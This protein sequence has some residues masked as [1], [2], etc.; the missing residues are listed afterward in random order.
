MAVRA[1]AV[2]LLLAAVA[3]AQSPALTTVQDTLFGATGTVTITAAQTFTTAD[4]Y[5][6][7]KG[8]Q[9]VATLGTGGALSVALPPNVGSTPSGTY[10]LAYYQ[11][12][13]G[14]PFTETWVVPSTPTTVDLA[15]V[16]TLLPPT[17]S[18]MFAF[19]QINAPP[20]CGNGQIPQYVAPGWDCVNSSGTGT[21]TSVGLA[22]PSWLAVAGSPVTTTGTLTLAAATGQTTHEVLGTGTGGSVALEALALADLPGSGAATLNTTSPLTGGGSL[23]LGGSLTLACASCLTAIPAPTATTLGGVESY[24]A[25]AHEWFDA[26]STGGVFSAS[27]PTFADLSGAAA[28]G[29]IPNPA[30]DVTGTYAATTVTGLHFG[31]NGYA[32][33]TAALTSGNCLGY[34][35]SNILGVSCGSGM[36][37]PMTAVGDMILGGTGG[38]PTRL[39]IGTSGQCL[40]SN[41][42]TASW[43][44]CSAGS[45]VT[46]ETNSANNS[47][48]TVLN[49]LN[50][51]AF[52]GLTETFTNTSGGDVQAGFSGTLGVGGGGTGLTSITAGD[53]IAGNGTGTPNLVATG[54]QGQVLE[55]NGPGA[56]PSYQDPIISGAYTNLLD[57]AAATATVTGTYTRVWDFSGYATLYVTY[58]GITGSPA[59]C[60]IQ[61]KAGDS[62][63]NVINDGSAI[64]TAPANGTTTANITPGVNTAAGIE[65][66]YAC[67]TYPTAGTVSVDYVP[68]ATVSVPNTVATSASQSGTWTVAQSGTWAQNLTELAGTALGAPAAWGTAPSGDVLGVNANVLALPPLPAG[69]NA[70]GS[71][72]ISNFPATQPVSGTVTA[73]AGTGFRIPATASAA[74][75]DSASGLTQVIAAVTGKA[76][77]VAGYTVVANA[78]VTVQWEYGTGTACA[79]GT[80]ALTGPMSFAA[81]GGAA[82]RQTLFVPSGDALCL[83]LGAAVQ[84]GG[85]VSYAQQ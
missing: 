33:G 40:T 54:T 44:A 61:L 23:A 16:R 52:N 4:G 47:S 41:G 73:D 35:G 9:V 46:L 32:L 11:V 84:V 45:G 3:W 20:G 75:N 13:P 43:G 50:S 31:S 8:Y 83:N 58:A 25:P 77:Y 79:T 18:M 68:Q 5:V 30:G 80:T 81:N 14:G 74:I 21:V 38:A 53:L 42:T 36:T 59:G 51:A 17:P 26:L 67:T 39:A 55:S 10:Y 64:S 48:Q 70:I 34:N 24:T 82:P 63:G 15:A 12:T 56:A 27:Q 60:T 71:V 62:L 72:S 66:V 49:L 78:A 28:A 19:N 1:L 37:N 57:A 76:I 7:P 22:A 29:Q 65:A 2:T 85:S 69:S 6:I